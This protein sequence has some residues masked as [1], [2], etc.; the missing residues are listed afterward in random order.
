M[1]K[2]FY[3][4]IALFVLGITGVHAAELP[5][6]EPYYPSEYQSDQD[7]LS[8]AGRV[9]EGTT[10]PVSTAIVDI[11]GQVSDTPVKMISVEAMYSDNI[12]TYNIP[13]SYGFPV[14]FTGNKELLNLKLVIPY[15]S[16][17]VGSLSDSGLGDISLTTNYLVRFPNLL[18]DSKLVIK[19]PTGEYKKADVPLG[20]GST[21]VGLYVDGTWY[22][23]SFILK[24]GLGYGYNGDYDLDGDNITYGDEYL[25][26]G[27]VDYKINETMKTGGLFVYKARAEDEIDYAAVGSLNTYYPGMNTLDFIPNFT[28]YYSKYNIELI[29]T[30]IIPVS[31][32]WNT[33]SGIEPDYDPDR[34]M[35]F[36]ISCSK[37]F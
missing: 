12:Q 13:I 15:T 2:L 14:S 21:D 10:T 37:P 9:S 34:S 6:A 32:S 4:I 3:Y 20:T 35:S 19:A 28:Y 27:G 11:D 23:D 31:D 1:K 7:N 5:Y 33:D 25:I 29:A 17:E 26:S 30:A 24:G 18:L 36:S 8:N 16:R 22:M